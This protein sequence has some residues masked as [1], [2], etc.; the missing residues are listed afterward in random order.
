VTPFS[1]SFAI[2]FPLLT[3]FVSNRFHFISFRFSFFLSCAATAGF[4]GD[5]DET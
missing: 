3:N 4:R 5:R 2:S 1:D